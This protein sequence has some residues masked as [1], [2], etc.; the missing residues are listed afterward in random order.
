MKCMRLAAAGSRR[1]MQ[2]HPH[3]AFELSSGNVNRR[4]F[5][6]SYLPSEQVKHCRPLIRGLRASSLV[7]PKYLYLGSL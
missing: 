6:V 5:S 7:P 3:R 2:V 4:L 1:Y